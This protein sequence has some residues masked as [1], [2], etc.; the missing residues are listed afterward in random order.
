MRSMLAELAIPCRYGD[1]ARQTTTV[2]RRQRGAVFDQP[3]CAELAAG[4]G[5]CPW[6]S[7]SRDRRARE[8]AQLGLL[9]AQ[10]AP[11]HVP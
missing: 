7:Q 3:S 11:A 6:L 2:K 4:G 8:A 1:P 9:S 5:K 10:S